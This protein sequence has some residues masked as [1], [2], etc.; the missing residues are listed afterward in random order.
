MNKDLQNLV[1]NF[2]TT[3]FI[4]AGAGLSRRYYNLPSWESLL[5]LFIDKITNNDPV[6]WA[7]Y[8]QSYGPTFDSIA[9]QVELDFNK[10]WFDD[11]TIRTLSP[12]LMQEVTDKNCSPFKAEIASHITSD[13]KISDQYINEIKTLK[14]L[15]KKNISGFI[16]TNYD[17]FLEYLAPDYITY[18]GQE[19]LIFSTIQNIAEIYKIHGSI[20]DPNTIIIT[21]EDYQKFDEKAAYLSAKLMTI[22]LEYPIIFIG[23]SINDSNIRK[24]LTSIIT[25]LSPNNANK[26]S[27]RFIFV[28]HN[29]KESPAIIT[30]HSID[31]GGQLISVTKISLYDYSE[32]YEALKEKHSTLPV[33]LLRMFKNDFYHYVLTDTPTKNLYVAGINDTRVTDQDLVLAIAS[34][35]QLGLKGL[36]GV[37]ADEL[38]RDI[39][40]NTL[41]N[42][43]DEILTYAYPKIIKN[44]NKLAV[45]KYLKNATKSYPSIEKKANIH[46]F[47][48]LLNKTIRD[49]RSKKHLSDRSISGLTVTLNYKELTLLNKIN[50]DICFLSESEINLDDLYIHLKKTLESHPTIFSKDT[51]QNIKSNLR[52]LI[53]IYDWMKYGK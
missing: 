16:T 28:E 21:A 3:P 5:K 11:P 46:C 7:K 47:D 1:K 34:P 52:R 41:H 27:N 30:P 26:L 12:D 44:T 10:K 45:F 4:F 37:E 14:A 22:F 31:I 40:L 2:S 33:K 17:N 36:A 9:S 53:R 25:C 38:Y 13:A 48:D 32:L 29:H 8:Y 43:A 6:G 15:T 51:N 23:Y 20:S 39:I 18:I 50:L 24:I 42:D 19:E 35:D 49:G